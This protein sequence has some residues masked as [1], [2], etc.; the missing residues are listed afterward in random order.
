MPRP[1]GYSH[2]RQ[3]DGHF[4]QD[5]NEVAWVDEGL[6][7]TDD[8]GHWDSQKKAP[9]G[10]DPASRGGPIPAGHYIVQYL[11]KYKHF[12][13]AARLEQTLTSVMF[14][15]VS[16]DIGLSATTRDGFLIHGM[17]PKGSDGCIVPATRDSLNRLM[18]ALKATKGAETL[19]VVG[20]GV[21][22][23]KLRNV[24]GIA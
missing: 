14:T 6:A 8:I 18:A 13:L 16:S 23:S 2:Q 1:I 11:G 22:S 10:F 17:G 20:G 5:A 15:D 3:H 21:D 12:G 7:E 19:K 9:P 4:N 24:G